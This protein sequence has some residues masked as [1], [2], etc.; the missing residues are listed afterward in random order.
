ML[1]APRIPFQPLAVVK[2]RTESAMAAQVPLKPPG[3]HHRDLDI[4]DQGV[5]GCRRVE[6]GP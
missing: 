3:R 5:I 6:R 2:P 4:V 1:G